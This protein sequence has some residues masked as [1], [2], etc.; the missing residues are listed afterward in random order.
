MDQPWPTNKVTAAAGGGAL[1]TLL[2][3]CAVWFGATE[4]PVGVEGAAATLG[5][6]LMG[7]FVRETRDQS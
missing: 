6:F 5:A 7:Y 1:G 3:A 2:V 4:P